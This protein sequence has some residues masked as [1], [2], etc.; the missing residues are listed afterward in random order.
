MTGSI[1]NRQ[2]SST[3]G[4]S[5]KD[6]MASLEFRRCS[7]LDEYDMLNKSSDTNQYEKTLFDKDDQISIDN[8]SGVE[9]LDQQFV[10]LACSESK[11]FND[12]NSSIRFSP[13]QNDNFEEDSTPNINEQTNNSEQVSFSINNDRK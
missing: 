11:N 10:N 13:C 5:N 1:V 3:A 2:H 6:E 12:D 4:H 8:D 9:D 7:S